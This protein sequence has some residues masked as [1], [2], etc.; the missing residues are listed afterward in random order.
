MRHSNGLRAVAV[1]VALVIALA[2]CGS[3]EPPGPDQ[4][5]LSGSI[6]TDFRVDSPCAEQRPPPELT[7]VEL[8]FKDAAGKV[9]GTALTGLPD[10]VELPKGPGT[11]TWVH[12]GCRIFAPYAAILPLAESYSVDFKPNAAQI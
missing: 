5:R 3:S 2:G 8:T 12:G 9:L 6:F 7:G 4:L 1:A 11:E 10:V